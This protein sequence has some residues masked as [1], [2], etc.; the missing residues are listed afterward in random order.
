MK[1]TVSTSHLVAAAVIGGAFAAGFFT[2]PAFAEQPA[3]KRDPFQFDF[4]FSPDELTSTP[5]A[6][7]LLIRLESRV[8]DHCGANVRMTVTERKQAKEC[9]GET[10]KNSISKFGSE[11]VAQAY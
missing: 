7:K 4:S 8:R 1:T 11:T 6:E 5:K 10:M 3:E 2:G 9:I